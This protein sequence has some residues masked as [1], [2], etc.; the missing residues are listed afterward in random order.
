M[1]ER[2]RVTADASPS[3]ST[4]ALTKPSVFAWAPRTARPVPS[5]SATH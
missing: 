1:V 5:L 4:S 2:K 3:I